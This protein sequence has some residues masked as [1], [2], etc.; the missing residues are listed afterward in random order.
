MST[1]RED[2]RRA[3][4]GARHRLEVG[5]RSGPSERVRDTLT[6]LG[7]AREST[8]LTHH[9]RV[10]SALSL[11]LQ[12]MARQKRQT[13]ADEKRNEWAVFIGLDQ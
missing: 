3:G 9:N 13:K 12:E 1:Q 8:R 4:D 7:P 6:D 11:V 2:W 5:G 10:Q